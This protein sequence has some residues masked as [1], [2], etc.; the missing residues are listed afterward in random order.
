MKRIYAY[1]TEYFMSN[2]RTHRE[3][4][5]STKDIRTRTNGITYTPAQ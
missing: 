1:N 2:E 4:L 3:L 5:Q